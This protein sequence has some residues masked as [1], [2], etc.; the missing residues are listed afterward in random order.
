MKIEKNDDLIQRSWILQAIENDLGCLDIKKATSKN[1]HLYADLGDIVR[2]LLAAPKVDAVQVV[3]CKN[4]KYAMRDEYS[5]CYFCHEKQV[6]AEHYCS[7]GE[8]R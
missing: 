5:G 8:R 1:A 2:M 6:S 3:R 7:K 4:C